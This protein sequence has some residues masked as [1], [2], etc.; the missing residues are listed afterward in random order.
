MQYHI[1]LKAAYLITILICILTI[2]TTFINQTSYNIIDSNFSTSLISSSTLIFL[3]MGLIFLGFSLI[4]LFH[5]KTQIGKLFSL[6]LM[7]VSTCSLLIN[8]TLHYKITII[9]IHVLVII[10]NIILYS[11]IGLLTYLNHKKVYKICRW[12]LFIFYLIQIT[13]SLYE[14]ISG[15]QFFSAKSNFILANYSVTIFIIFIYLLTSYRHSTHYTHKQIKLLL[16]GLLSGLLIFLLYSL[17]PLFA[18]VKV[19]HNEEVFLYITSPEALSTVDLYRDVQSIIIF[20]GIIAV[21]IYI[22]IKREYLLEVHKEFWQIIFVILYMIIVNIMMFYGFNL[23]VPAYY[24]LFNI[25]ISTPLLL[26]YIRLRFDQTEAYNLNLLK[27]LDE[28]RQRISIYLHD[29]VLQQLIV[30]FH[31]DESNDKLASLISDIRNLSHDLYPIIVDD[32]GLEHSLAVFVDELTIDHNIEIK[33]EYL[34]PSGVIPNYI[35]VIV[36]RTVKELITNAIK[37]AK[38]DKINIQI[39]GNRHV[40]NIIVEDNGT[41]FIVKEDGK[42]LKSPHMGLYTVKKQIKDLNGQ[43]RFQSDFSIGTRYDISI[44]LSDD[45]RS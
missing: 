27:S 35:A 32:L 17:S 43:L 39:N 15:K 31:K 5:I 40:L 38:C 24:Y 1:K 37:H 4:I 29:E 16:L 13:A 14:E 45:W 34:Y 26:A 23:I 36:Y 18:I 10:S 6:Y 33:Y 20:T 44:P 22:L 21:I 9:A 19:S 30:I 8:M 2:P 28:E 25:I 12:I 11:L 41:G 42:L 7:L 3:F